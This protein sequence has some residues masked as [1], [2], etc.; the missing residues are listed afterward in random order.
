MGEER[1]LKKAISDESVGGKSHSGGQG[2]GCTM[3]GLPEKRPP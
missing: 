1:L 3:D 2:K